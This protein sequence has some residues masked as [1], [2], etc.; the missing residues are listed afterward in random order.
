MK[1]DDIVIGVEFYVKVKQNIINIREVCDKLEQMGCFDTKEYSRIDDA[2]IY[3]MSIESIRRLKLEK[4]TNDI[5]GVETNTLTDI[6]N[7]LKEIEGDI[8]VSNMVFIY[9]GN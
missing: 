4:I 9:N 8:V 6:K 7:K 3:Y 1:I 5:D 2:P